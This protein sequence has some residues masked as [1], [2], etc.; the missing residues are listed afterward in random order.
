MRKCGQVW[1]VA[2]TFVAPNNLMPRTLPFPQTCPYLHPPP[3]THIPAPY[4]SYLSTLAHTPSAHHIRIVAH[5]DEQR[6]Q[7]DLEVEAV[8]SLK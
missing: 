5:P 7:D 4:S 2:G 3:S 6:G 1:G 8:A